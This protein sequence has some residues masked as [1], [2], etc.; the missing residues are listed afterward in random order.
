MREDFVFGYVMNKTSSCFQKYFPICLESM[1][2]VG[3]TKMQKIMAEAQQIV[4]LKF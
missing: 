4:D 3:C 2:E 1:L